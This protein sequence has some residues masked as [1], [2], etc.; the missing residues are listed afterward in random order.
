[1]GVNN[2]SPID[3]CSDP[4][5]LG[6]PVITMTTAKN[7][8]EELNLSITGESVYVDYGDGAPVEYPGDMTVKGQ[9]IKIYGN[10]I[11]YLCCD[12]NQLTSLDLSNDA[13]LE[14]V[15]CYNNLLTSLEVP[16][17]S[18]LKMLSCGLNNLTSLDISGCTALETLA[19]YGNPIATLNASGCSSLK[20]VEEYKEDGNGTLTSLNVAGCTSVEQIYIDNNPLTA[21]D[22]SRCS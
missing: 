9:N 1:M 20:K 17:G 16:K 19:D 21:L 3:T 2:V 14:T 18:A 7:N 12:N 4:E 22:I 8:G 5:T 11:T 13:Q 6:E 15:Y 10:S